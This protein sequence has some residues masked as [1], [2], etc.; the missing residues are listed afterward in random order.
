M[1]I[2]LTYDYELFFGEHAG[3]VEKCMLEPTNDLFNLA[4]GKDVFL[5]FFVDV[6]YLIQAEKYSDLKVELQTVKDQIQKMIS[7]GHDVQ[8]HI[9]PHWEK[10]EYVNGNWIMNV[11]GS[12]KLSDFDSTESDAIVRKYKAYLEQLIGRKV[13]AFRAGGWCIQPFDHLKNVFKETGIKIDSSVISGDF[14]MTHNYAI[15]FRDAPIKSKYKFEDDVCQEDDQGSFLE[16][17]ISSLRYSPLFFWRLYILGR[18]SPDNHKMIGDG[19]FLSQGGRKKRVLR[20]FTSSHVSSDGYYASK[21]NAALDK[22]I[23]MEQEEMIVIGHP[24][25]NT[26]FSIKALRKFIEKNHK[27]HQFISFQQES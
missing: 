19:I 14:M 12:Y 1:K 27:K 25:G 20:T 8:L 11:D 10:A 16:Y 9:H 23:N 2:F 18:L 26:K 13:N 24:K 3:S 17:P 15:D 21:L 6:G 4:H 5:T 7:L 22:S